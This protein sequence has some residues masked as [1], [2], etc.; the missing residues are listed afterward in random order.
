M[1]ISDATKAPTA[2]E[3]SYLSHR[4][5]LV[6]L[7]GLMAGMFL[8]ALDQSIVGTALPRIVSDLGGLNHLSWVV[9]VYLL[10]S[11]ASTPL[12]GKISDLYGRRP[13]FQTA[14][15][16]FLAGSVVAAL[17]GSMG[18]LIGGRAIQGLGAGGLMALALSIIGDIIPPRERGR[19]QGYF[20][21]VFGLSSVG[22]PLLGGWFTDGPGWQWIFWIN[23]PIGL[24]A[25]VITSVALKMPKVRRDHKIDYL[26]AAVIVASV[27]S[28]LLYTAWAG[29]EFGWA[30]PFSLTLL[31][32]GVVLAA[33]FV[34]VEAR[35]EEPIIPL[36]LF[37][38]RVFAPTI[39]FVAIMGLA[40]F[41]GIIFLP[42]YLQVVQG[43][44]PTESGLALLPMM[45]GL[46]TTSIGSG[47]LV[48]RNGRYKVYPILGAGVTAIGILLL[49]TLGVDTPYWQIG[50]YFYVFGAG[51][52]FTMQI[53]VTAVQNAVERRDMGSA[54]SSVMFFRSMGAAF[55]TAIFGAVLTSRLG[56][57][58]GEAGAASGL[59]GGA[60]ESE[61]ANN[62]HA[63]QALPPDLHA[64]V[65][66]AWVHS[67]RDV[68]LVALPFV[69]LAFITAFF[70]P[71]LTLKTAATAEEAP[72]EPVLAME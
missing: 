12:W 13:I 69:L 9:T 64:I 3:H 42:V 50:I 19:Y 32:A 65:V 4:Q 17:A 36:R 66:D 33:L 53:V 6:V 35:A 54:T 14:I 71:E 41:G 24:G 47:Q 49:S 58:L 23:I 51:L 2:D 26:G 55:G 38:N 21:A 11:T 61:I 70:I 48:T 60:D 25:L 63:I 10:T 1:S 67:L 30:D 44:S 62:V 5:I 72:A 59:P 45:A 15:V 40:M 46:F 43:M 56:H 31:G 68:F 7:A 16:I 22:G 34:L 39:V 18:V 27:S 28:I 57:H 37:R 8:A 20:G 52:G 29:G